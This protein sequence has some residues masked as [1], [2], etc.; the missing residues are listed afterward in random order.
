MGLARQFLMQ[1]D[2]FVTN[3]FPQFHPPLG[4]Y[5]S[6]RDVILPIVISKK[7]ITNTKI[8]FQF[9]PGVRVRLTRSTKEKN[10]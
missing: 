4:S 6:L 1:T 7:G 3:C 8:F 5:W 2:Y 9:K 10:S